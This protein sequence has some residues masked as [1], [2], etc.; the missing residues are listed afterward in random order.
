VAWNV[1]VQGLG[2]L[3]GQSVTGSGGSEK[4]STVRQGEKGLELL[5]QGQY[6]EAIA[7]LR[8][9]V[10]EAPDSWRYTLGLAEALLS[11]NYNFTGLRFLQQVHPQFHNLAE[12]HYTLGLAYYLCYKYPEAIREFQTIPHDDPGF[13]RVSF[14]IGNCHMAMGDLRQAEALFRRA[15]ELKPDE[16]TYYVSLGKMLRMEGPERLDEAITALKKA[17]DLRPHDA[18]V[19]LHLA[20]CEEGKGDY[21]GAQTLLE[22]VIQ[23]Q[24][25]LQPA[26]VALANA[27]QH[28]HEEAKARQQREI[29]A[30]L[31][32]P[33]PIR[34]LRLGP[35]ASNLAPH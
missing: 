16:A 14:L 13:S 20:Y 11:A 31:K 23:E 8:Q 29:A 5:S 28:N 35:V 6:K 24:P 4:A 19:K 26:R 15:I 3:A 22:Q 1:P 25:D 12:Y 21:Q 9:A 27:Y 30:R 10:R 32:P 34:H 2:R 18:Y 7:E 17:L 33:E